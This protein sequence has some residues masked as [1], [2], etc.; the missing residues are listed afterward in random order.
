MT[1]VN[2]PS[3]LRPRRTEKR[4]RPSPLV[5]P[6]IG[7]IR[8]VQISV[9]LATGLVVS[10]STATPTGANPRWAKTFDRAMQQSADLQVWYGAFVQAWAEDTKVRL[11]A[12]SPGLAATILDAVL[13]QARPVSDVDWSAGA[14]AH[15]FDARMEL[16]NSQGWLHANLGQILRHNQFVVDVGCSDAELAAGLIKMY[17]ALARHWLVVEPH[18]SPALRSLLLAHG[19]PPRNIIRRPLQYLQPSDLGSIGLVL[20]IDAALYYGDLRKML[21]AHSRLLP[22]GGTLLVTT[23]G[24]AKGTLRDASARIEFRAQA[25]VDPGGNL[26]RPQEYLRAVE[27]LR[28]SGYT[29]HDDPPP[30]ELARHDQ[31]FSDVTTVRPVYL[32]ERTGKPFRAPHYDRVLRLPSRNR[33]DGV[34]P[35]MELLRLRKPLAGKKP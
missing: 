16:L 2:S 27:G 29:E 35:P 32:L 15:S 17:P 20:D 19:I 9:F 30:P 31:I 12:Y 24:L 33:G 26:I 6:A 3:G 34:A 21:Y 11:P 23:G 25:I 8:C 5:Q 10:T 13:S 22:P 1:P 14:Y 28:L 18:L 7:A 4:N